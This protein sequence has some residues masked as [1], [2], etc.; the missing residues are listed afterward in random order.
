MVNPDLG[1]R[2][3]I[4]LLRTLTSSADETWPTQPGWV[5]RTRSLPFVWTLNQL[6]ITQAA[7]AA[8]V[9]EL[10]TEHQGDLPYRHIVV[11][12]E[13]TGHLLED[14]LGATGWRTD[15]EVLMVLIAEPDRVVDTSEVVELRQEQMLG[16]MRRWQT[17]K[18]QGISEEAL[19]QLREY[20]QLEPRIWHER[21]FGVIDAEGEPLA[22]TKV[23]SK[24]ATSWVEDVYVVP[25]ARGQGYARML[26][27]YATDLARSAKHDLVFILA[28]DNDWPKHLYA[29]V[30]FRPVGTTHTFHLERS[31][32]PLDIVG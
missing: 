1:N 21:S 16:L 25:E 8:E 26:V 13:T 10:A 23:R 7:T 24:D 6:R 30:G 17:E 27:S 11:E 20:K 18:R 31:V 12:D 32:P 15:R 4:E 28:D 14:E 2:I 5:F 19:D 22:L 3:L 29:S 9:I